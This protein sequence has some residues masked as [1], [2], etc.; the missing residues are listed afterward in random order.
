MGSGFRVNG[1]RS[2]VKGLGLGVWVSWLR[3]KGFEV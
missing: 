1:L 2:R 3:V